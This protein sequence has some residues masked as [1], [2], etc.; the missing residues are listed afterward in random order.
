ML[1]AHPPLSPV[2]PDLDE[3]EPYLVEVEDS[4]GRTGFADAHISPGSSSETREGGW[5]FCLRK[6]GEMIGREPEDAKQ[7]VLADFAASKVAATA[8]VTAIEVMEGS[9]LID[10]N[11]ARPQPLL[12]P[13]NGQEPARHRRRDR[14]L[15]RAGFRTFK[16]KVG[17]DV[18]A[19]L[20]RVAAIQAACRGRASLR[21]DA[22]RAYLPRGR[23]SPSPR[24]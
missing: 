3:F 2:V 11:V 10:V 17:K 16:V 24:A 21:L 15:A 8:L 4:D 6:M 7:I 23:A 18:E 12:T 13:I 5:A 19:D 20:A 14:G 9:D 22:N 1:T